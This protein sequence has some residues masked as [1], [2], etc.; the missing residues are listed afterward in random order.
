VDELRKRTK[1]VDGGT[2]YLFATTLEN[3]DRVLIKT[4]KI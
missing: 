3:G 1:I 2:I 4:H